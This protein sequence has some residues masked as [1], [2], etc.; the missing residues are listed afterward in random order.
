MEP[1][2]IVFVALSSIALLLLPR[3]FAPVPLLLACAWLS[4]D[5]VLQIGSVNL[6][7][8]QMLVPVGLLRVALKGER[9][10]GGLHRMDLLWILWA[11]WMVTSN[12]LFHSDP[13]VYRLGI[14]WLYLGYY[15]VFRALLQDAEDV[16]RLFRVTCLLFVPVAVLMLIEHSTG[17]NQF[18]YLSGVQSLSEVRNGSVRARGPY[19]HPT[20][21]GA[22]GATLL[23]MAVYLWSRHRISALLG[24]FASCSIVY[25]SNSSGPILMTAFILLALVMWYVRMYLRMILWC[26][27]IGVCALHWVMNDPVYF[28][29]AKVDVVGG[30]AGWHRAQLIRASIEHLHEWWLAGTDYTRHW[31]PTGI[32]ANQEH[33]DFTNH[34]LVIGAMG[35]LPLMLLF[36]FIMV[37][38]FRTLG[39]ALRHASQNP[40]RPPYGTALLIWTLGAILFGHL[41]NFLTISLFDHSVISYL[42]IL[43]SAA[44]FEPPRVKVSGERRHEFSRTQERRLA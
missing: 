24:L 44:A 13:L 9:L 5:P 42:V 7:V 31:M 30:S 21:A 18:S 29:M 39:R 33:T 34:Y 2:G 20:L 38:A 25:A 14:I 32:P 35:G 10:A 28:L 41:T 19:I 4:R 16:A 26:A 3:R 37:A 36:L 43:A 22:V 40:N 17:Y 6:T 8:H 15:F 23:P 12:V 27:L 1:S 11:V